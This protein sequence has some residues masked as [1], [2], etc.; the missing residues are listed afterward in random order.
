M[1]HR[2]VVG[3]FDS[4]DLLFESRPPLSA[5]ICYDVAECLP[6]FTGDVITELSET[7]LIF[8]QNEAF[9]ARLR[10]Q[11]VMCAAS[12]IESIL[13]RHG[14]IRRG[15]RW[16]VVVVENSI[17]KTPCEVFEEIEDTCDV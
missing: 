10:R 15:D 13:N 2:I 1:A 5:E 4:G 8:L 7:Q 9:D 3:T 17:G 11:N 6:G 14:L 16:P 12:M